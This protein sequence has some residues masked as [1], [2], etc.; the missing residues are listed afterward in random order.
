MSNQQVEMAAVPAPQSQ[1]VAARPVPPLKA[2]N[3]F[4]TGTKTQEYLNKVL[5]SEKNSFVNNIVSLVSNAPMLQKC[6]PSGV[7]YAALK[8]TALKLPL[9]PNLGF[10][11]VIPYGG[12]AQFQMGW[13]GFVQLALRT[14]LYRTIN[15]RDVRFGEIQ[16]EDFVSGEMRFK[17]LP[18]IERM[19]API[20]GYLAYF[21]LV[22][23]FRKMSYWTVEEI[24]AHAQK[25]SKTYAKGDSVWR[26]DFNGMAKKTVLKLLIGKFG[27]MSVDMQ[28]ALRDDQAV[29]DGN[30]AESYADNDAELVTTFESDEAA[31]QGTADDAAKVMAAAE[32]TEA[33]KMN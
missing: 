19:N 32:A 17:A 25:F 29:V 30:G 5:G 12:K 9:D 15:V 24:T 1:A 8:A 27:P 4:I 7:M 6:E 3:N 16:D 14:N 2:F 18:S 21:E 33:K 11:Y 28:A 13:K 10:A 22:N 31:A 23:G 26:T 20:V